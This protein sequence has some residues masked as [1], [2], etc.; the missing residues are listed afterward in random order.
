MFD[1]THVAKFRS[2]T[3]STYHLGLLFNKNAF[4]T[5]KC[6][7]FTHISSNQMANDLINLGCIMRKSLKLEWNPSIP[8]GLV[9]HFTRGYF[10]G[11]G[12]LSFDKS[13][14]NFY[15]SFL[16]TDSFIKSLH[17]HIKLHVLANQRANGSIIC[18]INTNVTRLQFGGNQSPMSILEWMYHQSDA[19][20]RLDR[21]YELYQLFQRIRHVSPEERRKQYCEFIASNAWRELIECRMK[22]QC[23]RIHD[24]PRAN[25]NMNRIAQLNMQGDL[26]RIWDRAVLIKQELGFSTSAILT[27]CRGQDRSKKTAYGFKW[28]FVDN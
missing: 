10:D 16:G 15:L 27:I 1:Y 7:A 21:K 22:N 28:K 20:I 17:S 18:Q 25:Q 3:E 5:D 11:D 13:R 23:P 2:A 8:H 14:S 4:S 26:I 24:I 19:S 9:S 6:I 12:C